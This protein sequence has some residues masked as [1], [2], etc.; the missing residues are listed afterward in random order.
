V[1]GWH[2]AALALLTACQSPPPRPSASPPFT[3]SPIATA[4]RTVAPA[5]LTPAPPSATPALIPATERTASPIQLQTFTPTAP[6][7]ATPTA[8]DPRSQL[9]AGQYVLYVTLDGLFAASLDGA[10]R[11]PLSRAIRTLTAALSPDGDTVA[12]SNDS[13]LELL[14]LGTGGGGPLG[15][16]SYA[17]LDITWSPDGQALAVASG[18]NDESASLYWVSRTTGERARLTHADTF[19]RSIAW[20]PDGRWLVFASDLGKL[21]PGGGAAASVTELYLM[22]TGCLSA[23]ASCEAAVQPFTTPGRQQGSDDPAWSPD[24]QSVVFRC[25]FLADEVFQAELC[26]QTLADG[27]FTRLTQTPEDE[28]DPHWSPDGRYLAY[29]RTNAETGLHEVFV[30]DA[31]TGAVRNVTDTPE[32]DESLIGWIEVE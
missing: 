7:T 1:R 25:G 2:L 11:V 8:I 14:D 12:F 31:A 9:A 4:T 30:L 10:V 32:M 28:S 21:E 16:R 15:P 18:A 22:D 17:L 29:T 23:P 13:Q 6:P 27:T 20:S 24:S 19:E 5:A 26:E 3:A